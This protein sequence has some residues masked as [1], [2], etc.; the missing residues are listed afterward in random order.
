MPRSTISLPDDLTDIALAL[1]PQLNVWKEEMQSP[2]GDKHSSHLLLHVIPFFVEVMLQDGVYWIHSLKD[3]PCSRLLVSRL[4]TVWPADVYGDYTVWA[5]RERRK[6]KEKVQI[7]DPAEE[8]VLTLRSALLKERGESAMM[9]VSIDHLQRENDQHV[10]MIAFL[11]NQLVAATAN[12]GVRHRVEER[13]LDI[14]PQPQ[15]EQQQQQQQEQ[16]QQQQQQQQQPPQPPQQQQRQQLQQLQH[17][18]QQQ[19]QPAAEVLLEV[20][21]VPIFLRD[22]NNPDKGTVLPLGK[23]KT[24]TY[25]ANMYGAHRHA[26]VLQGRIEVTVMEGGSKGAIHM[27]ITKIKRIHKFLNAFDIQEGGLDIGGVVVDRMMVAAMQID[28]KYN[29]GEKK[30]QMSISQFYINLTQGNYGE[31]FAAKKRNKRPRTVIN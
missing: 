16:Q 25:L 7:V 5:R 2:N 24:I 20:P 15:H 23:Y 11:R 13:P 30:D 6:C 4:L 9:Q 19:Q 12:T 26:Y 21:R 8:S 17:Q 3:N 31:E 14:L 1:F 29:I 27:N 28:Q 18:Q 10:S 22:G